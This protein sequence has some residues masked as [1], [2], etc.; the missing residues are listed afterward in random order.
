MLNAI[1]A[2]KE[3]AMHLYAMFCDFDLV[4][5]Y[6]SIEPSKELEKS[7]DELLTFA[8]T[9]SFPE[10][11]KTEQNVTTTPNVVPNNIPTNY[12][13]VNTA[14]YTPV[15]D[16]MVSPQFNNQNPFAPTGT[17]DNNVNNMYN[18]VQAIQ[19]PVRSYN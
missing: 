17:V 11:P 14:S 5:M 4:E 16:N 18:N 9:G 6:K 19:R 1:Y 15:R 10:T 13:S 8:T 12:A 7:F 2:D 3:K